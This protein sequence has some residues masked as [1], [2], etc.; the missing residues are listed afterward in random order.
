MLRADP[1]REDPETLITPSEVARLLFVSPDTV[2]AWTDAGRLP[3]Q[4]TRAGHRLYRRGD[5]DRFA[6]C[7]DGR[8]KK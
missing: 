2:R 5:V 3:C 8:R 6:K 1:E 7:D 4:R